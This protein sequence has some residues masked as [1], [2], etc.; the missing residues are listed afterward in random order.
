MTSGFVP[1]GKVKNAQLF[2]VKLNFGLQICA[3]DQYQTV[4]TVL[5]VERTK[6]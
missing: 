4:L 6:L 3:V 5:T 2:C 1:G